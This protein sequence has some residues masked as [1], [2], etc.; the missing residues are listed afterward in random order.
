MTWTG[1]EKLVKW[2][3][4]YVGSTLTI[5]AATNPNPFTGL[6]QPRHLWRVGRIDR[7]RPQAVGDEEFA[8][9]QESINNITTAFKYQKRGSP[10]QLLRVSRRFEHEFLSDKLGQR[11]K[12]TF[13]S[14]GWIFQERFLSPRKIFFTQSE[15][16]WECENLVQCECRE[17]TRKRKGPRKICQLSEPDPTTALDSRPCKVR[18]FREASLPIG[19]IDEE[20]LKVIRRWQDLI[21][22]QSNLSLTFPDDRLPSLSG[23]AKSFQRRHYGQYLAGIWEMELPLSLLWTSNLRRKREPPFQLPTWTWSSYSSSVRFFRADYTVQRRQFF[24]E[25]E[26]LEA[27]CVLATED[28]TGE[29]RSG[30]V[31]VRGPTALLEIEYSRI[32]G[33]I[34]SESSQT[35]GLGL[36]LDGYSIITDKGEQTIQFQLAL[37]LPTRFILEAGVAIPFKGTVDQSFDYG[38]LPKRLFMVLIHTHVPLERNPKVIAEDDPETANPTEPLKELFAERNSAEYQA[39]ERLRENSQHV[40]NDRS[41][42]DDYLDEIYALCVVESSVEVGKFEKLGV[43]SLE[44]GRPAGSDILLMLA[45]RMK[46]MTLTII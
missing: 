42:V 23:L 41:V 45:R 33:S 31:K 36:H 12:A 11:N 17:I 35:R 22:E 2:A 6:F 8:V 4:I 3:S 34:D 29:V 27:G 13:W 21:T 7:W 25:T 28:R 37:P 30:F 24:I 20:R 10:Q 32:N 14:R 18:Y 44:P 26:V 19:V 9:T 39:R 38:H 46:E 16:V 1:Q 15:A 43:F 40:Y 5:C